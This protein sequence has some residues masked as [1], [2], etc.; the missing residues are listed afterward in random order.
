MIDIRANLTEAQRLI[1]QALETLPPVPPA[2]LITTSEQLDRALSAA[3]PGD[4]VQLSNTFRS[5]KPVTIP[6]GVMVCGEQL[7][8]GRVTRDEPLPTFSGGLR[9]LGDAVGLYS[10]AVQ[11]MEPKTDIVVLLGISPVLNRCR[12]LGSPTLGGKRGI[13]ANG[14]DMIIAHCYVADIRQPAQDTQAIGAWDM[15]APG[16]IID[17]C[18]LEAAG[19]SV[20]LGGADPLDASRSPMRV[21]LKN[22]T[23]TKNP[24]WF[25]QAQI[26]CALE[27]KNAIGVSVTNCVLEYGG[28]SQGQG[29]YLIVATVRNQGGTAPYSAIK[30]V[31]IQG[32]TGGHAGGVMN[33]LGAD[34]NQ[35]SD[36]LD[37]L[38]LSDCTFVDIDPLRW[39]GS[40][41]LFMFDRAPKHVTIRNVSV[42][43]A[44]IN[45]LGYFS[46]APPTGLII[47]T[48]DLPPAKYGWKVDAGGSGRRALQA[49][50]PDAQLDSSVV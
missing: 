33:L 8:G 5:G 3:I 2:G 4:R 29:A 50:A 24:A 43:G 31:L 9:I 20:M 22:S 41:R 28:I 18:Y 42:E 26:K 10:V 15:A 7:E 17:D 49:Y 47:A 48:V 34:N 11:H 38:V 44:N 21:S 40:G 30:N 6:N 32:C 14:G 36:V 1:A 23:L 39:S 19:Q 35:T 45:A 37:G 27:L 46:G 13:A 25:G 16:L 12:I